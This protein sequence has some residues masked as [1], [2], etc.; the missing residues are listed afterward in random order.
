MID[1]NQFDNYE[2]SYF[3]RASRNSYCSTH[4]RWYPSLDDCPVCMEQATPYAKQ[5]FWVCGN[6]GHSCPPTWEMCFC[7]WHK[8]WGKGRWWMKKILGEV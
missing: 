5:E 8:E 1:P 7:G 3:D 4:G 6:C 2:E